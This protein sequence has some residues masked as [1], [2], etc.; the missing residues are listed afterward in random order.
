VHILKK[1][2]GYLVLCLF[3]GT[4]TSSGCS[5][6]NR[7]ADSNSS[8][9]TFSA[10]GASE[11]ENKTA[12]HRPIRVVATYSILG[13]LV[14]NIGGERIDLTVLVG[15]EGD[16]HTYEPTPQDS[17]ALAN[18]DIVF[19][20]GLGFEVWLEPL[21]QASQSKARRVVV[22]EFIK[23][24]D[25]AVSNDRTEIDPHVWHLPEN[26]MLMSQSITE[27]FEQ[28]DPDHAQ[29]YKQRTD[30]YL[31]EL[32]VLNDWI[33]TQTASLPKERRKLVT[34]HDTF[35][36]FADRYGFEVLSVLGS[37][38]SESSDP[39]A[40]QV[41]EMIQRVRSLEVPA[42]FAENIL[43]PELTNQIAK[44]A[45]V[46]VVPTLYTDALGLPDSPGK[47]YLSMMRFNVRTIVEALR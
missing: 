40:G 27:A 24:R 37:V 45:G 21:V 28:A 13:D 32:K 39:S 44:E 4:L 33:A 34:T 11:S 15:P 3:L 12:N 7:E 2:I 36:Y 18:A 16:A 20:N 1:S 6:E 38:S 26:A 14:R 25:L 47:D 9:G 8:V 31:K 19:E 41:A 10:T 22:T 42:I 30:A 35:G 17:R 23:P 46:N 43:N 5:R 29:N